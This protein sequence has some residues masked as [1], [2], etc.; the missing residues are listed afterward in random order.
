MIL[1]IGKELRMVDTEVLK[2]RYIE[3]VIAFPAVAVDD[4]VWHD[5][6]LNDGYQRRTGCIGYDLGVN[7]ATPLEQAKYRHFSCCPTTTLTFPSTAKITLVYLNFATEHGLTLSVLFT[8]DNL[9]KT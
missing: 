6:L 1:G 9:S 8:R 4:T 3:H 7:L 5:L 2:T